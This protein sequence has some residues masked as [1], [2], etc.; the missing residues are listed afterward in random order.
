MTSSFLL[1]LP[2][3]LRFRHFLLLLLPLL[4][5]LKRFLFFLLNL[6]SF[7][8]LAFTLLLALPIYSHHLWLPYFYPSTSPLPHYIPLPSP[9]LNFL[10][11]PLLHAAPT[12]CGQSNTILYRSKTYTTTI[13]FVYVKLTDITSKSRAVSMFL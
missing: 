4:V 1:L 8:L 10:L 12:E 6:F 7:R 9:R 13:N 5:F 3:L 11:H 2:T